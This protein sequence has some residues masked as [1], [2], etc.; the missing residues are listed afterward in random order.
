M[1]EP[2]TLRP[3]LHP[4]IRNILDYWK[5]VHPKTGLPGRQHIDPAD[6]PD[7]LPHVRLVDV[8]GDPPRFRVRLCGDRIRQHFG[9]SQQGRYYDEMYPGFTDRPTYAD[10]LDAIATR[11]PSWNKGACELNPEKIHVPLERVVLPLASDG[12]TVDMLLVISLF[13]E[14]A[15]HSTPVATGGLPKNAA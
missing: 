4:K 9:S 10:F 8:V 12:K 7:L 13:G 5:S 6:F 15:E 14:A 11:E 1:V 3:D 2:V